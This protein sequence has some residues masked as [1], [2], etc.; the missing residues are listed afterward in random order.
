MTAPARQAEARAFLKVERS[1]TGRKWRVRE[2]DDALAEAHRRQSGLP[3]IAARLLAARGVKLEDAKGFLAPTLRDFFPNPSSFQDMDRAAGVIDAAIHDGRACAVFA[4]YDV[5][6]GTSA[7]LLTRYF[8][9][10]GRDLRIYVPDRMA[11]GY[12][13]SAA[14]FARL[15]AEGC[16]LV[17]TV[18][19]GAAAYEALE[20]AAGIGLDVV[21][22][23]H[24]LMHGPPPP[25]LACVNPNR[26]DDTSGQG[27]LTAAGVV[28]V[29]LAA[30][31]R[32]ARAKG[33]F[34]ANHLPDLMAWLDLSALGTV[35]DVAPL[36]GFNRAVV[37]Q[38][39][40]V[41]ARKEKAGVRAL[42]EVAGRP[43]L[44]QVYDLGFVL[45]PRL[46]AGGRIGDSSLAARLLSTE[47]EAEAAEI[48]EKLD[49][50]NTERRRYEA[51]MLAD[52]AIE[53]EA[54][55]KTRPLVIV[56]RPDW[57][58]GVIGVAAGRLK[59]QL[60]KPVIVLGG[61]GAHAK[62]SGRSIG[63]VNLGAAVAAAA[64]AGVLLAGGGH[65][66]AA[67]LT[68]EWARVDE[69]RD[70]L[71]EA[72]QR[73][74]VAAEGEARTLWIDAVAGVPAVDLP[75]IDAM[76]RIG[77]YG[78]GHAEPVFALAD[79]TIGFAKLV[80]TDHV[81]CTLQNAGGVKISAIAFRAAKNALG[82]ALLKREGPLHVAVKLKRNAYG[83]TERAEAEILDAARA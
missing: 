42:A 43:N 16:Q 45:G 46:N 7:A 76:D 32:E 9:A 8:R 25:S 15:K 10:R 54:Q 74:T 26:M 77:P 51:E 53:A 73:E 66:M 12:G 21:V 34:G 44:G 22:I 36:T 3:E 58:P 5:D 79:V 6:G 65:A 29:L 31:N 14:A 63:G 59:E 64:K 55:A 81:R 83:G 60:M 11:E 41:L 18:D 68:V 4:D 30:L 33:S 20:A 47:D 80:G 48:A 71:S 1:L 78:P 82:E 39:L 38:G 24:H 17:I 57:H 56:G 27:H 69:L 19:C 72:L 13:P 23:D 52:A 75:L 61:E 40:K 49:A 35:C 70:F 62:G 28:L 37:A 2:A 50:L 67:G